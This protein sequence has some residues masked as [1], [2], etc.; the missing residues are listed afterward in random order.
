LSLTDTVDVVAFAELAALRTS[1]RA[2][3]AAAAGL[4]DDAVS[5]LV[6]SA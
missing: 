3:R 5:A 4:D 1:L 2:W 6:A